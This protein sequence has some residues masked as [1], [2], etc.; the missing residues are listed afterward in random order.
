MKQES[1]SQEAPARAAQL[2]QFAR[3]HLD[4][5]N[6]DSRM[7]EAI[8]LARLLADGEDDIAEGRTR[9]FRLFF[10][11]FYIKRVVV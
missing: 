1:I 4:E 3:R 8:A 7:T 6:I 11:E 10:K 2:R 9:S 5:V